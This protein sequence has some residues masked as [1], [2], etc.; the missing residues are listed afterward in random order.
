MKNEEYINKIVE[1]TGLSKKDIENLVKEKKE[2]LKGL[3][4]E[5]GALFV[6]AKEL[7]VDV[8]N[9]SKNILSD[10]ELNISDLTVNMKNIMLIGR[11]QD[12]YRVIKFEKNGGE[13]GF[14]GSFLLHDDT[15][16][17][18]IVLWDENV[19]LFNDERFKVDEIVKIV[20]GYAKEG[21][22]GGIEVH[23][24]KYSK[25]IIS[26]EDVDY[27]KFPKVEERIIN[28]GEINEKLYRVSIEGKI[29]NMF[30]PK[31]FTKKDG[32]SGKLQS[33]ILRDATGTVR[34]TFWNNEI[35][36]LK[37]NVVGDFI[38][39]SH[40]NVRKNAYSPNSLDLHATKQ[41]KLLK[42]KNNLNIEAKMVDKIKDLEIQNNIVSFQGII[43]SIEDLKKVNLKSG[44]EV[45][46]LNLNVSD[47]TGSIRVN[48]W[49]EM[50][51]ELSKSLK[52][53]DGIYLKNILV[54]HND[55]SGRYEASLIS[56][57]VIKKKND[58]KFSNLK[59]IEKSF[60]GHTND[61]LKDF[62]KIDTIQS[63]G[64]FKIKGYIPNELSKI[65]I[66]EACS[67]C[68]KKYE[69]CSCELK[70]SKIARMIINQ[71]FE[72][73]SGR[74]RATFIGDV[75]EKLVGTKAEIVTQLKDTPDFEELLNKVS[76]E[77][78]GRD[79]MIKGRVK[80]N[81]FTN[82]YEIIVVDFKELDIEE[83]LHNIIKEI[84][85]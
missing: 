58:L 80:F 70:G 83:E 35:D 44:E 26:P 15:G 1:D 33:L 45:S 77:I 47:D 56:D 69:N 20:N 67:N 6:I 79:L 37:D 64:F 25:L 52:N 36:K 66:Y 49:R 48:I 61:F 38:S 39:L 65:R 12:I 21:R 3:I 84:E 4:S 72:D 32:Q 76:S 24:G 59:T 63:P 7:G 46:L 28:I 62:T 43:T 18:R 51:D 23:I 9:E 27:K 57:S 81:D 29:A 55:F 71:A 82:A 34:I 5:E 13:E 11:I 68:N 73:E 22:Y 60:K 17:V 31:E 10:I 40:L 14:V 2:E 50:A 30:P 16:E 8:S 54:K 78:I 85:N 41:T 42:K 74:I 19:N 53:E 75:A